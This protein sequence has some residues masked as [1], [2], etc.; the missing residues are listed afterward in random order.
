ML[1]YC[2]PL[3][4]IIESDYPAGTFPNT[5]RIKRQLRYYG[6]Q[7]PLPPKD[8]GINGFLP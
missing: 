7:P 6:H 3:R 8:Y 4:K 1:S 5:K 2:A